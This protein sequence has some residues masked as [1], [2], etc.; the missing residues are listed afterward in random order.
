MQ[1]RIDNKQRKSPQE[2]FL[3]IIGFV[4]FIIYLVM[5]LILI[6]WTTFP[7]DMEPKYRIALGVILII[8]AIMRFLRYYRK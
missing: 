4:F 1:D 2:R 7:I 6:F 5:G 3:F 8:Y